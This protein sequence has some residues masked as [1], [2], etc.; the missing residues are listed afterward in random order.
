MNPNIARLKPYPFE[1]LANLLAGVTP[2]TGKSAISMSIGEPRH[3]PPG[4]VAES[5]IAHAGELGAYPT[6]R[7]FVELR[8]AMTQALT[9][10][11]VL[12]TNALDTERQILPVNGTREGLFSLV[13]AVMDGKPDALVV[14]PN[15]FYQIYEGAALLAGADPWFMNTTAAN[16]YKPDLATV[17]AAVWERTQLLFLCSPG[18]PTGAFMSAADWKL[19]FELA[20]RHDFVIA[21]DECYADLYT[22]ESAPPLGAL[23]V[24]VA[25]G[26]KDFRR[27]V[28]LHSLSKRSSV[29]GLRSGLIAGDA[30]IIAP[31]LAYRTYHGCAMPLITQHASITA[32]T[33]DVHVVANRK[34]YQTKLAAAEKILAPVLPV[35]I[36]PGAFYLWLAVPGG[37]DERFA[38]ELYAAE[39]LITLPGRYLS[40]TTPQ[41]DPGAGHVRISLVPEET[42][43]EEALLRLARFAQNYSGV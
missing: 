24:A 37:D 32:W 25:L 21:S 5:L 26:R 40:R 1:R 10:R 3:A 16:G 22:D 18:N 2:P 4:F 29:P 28:V 41:G 19:A 15:P 7:G 14:M 27:L 34:R 39:G 30:E 6:A 38:R 43:C 12:G 11:Y 20:D 35:E 8:T 42:L 31:L 9:R 13:Q 23:E 36:P 33:D 17:P